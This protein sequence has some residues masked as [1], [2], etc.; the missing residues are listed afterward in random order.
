MANPSDQDKNGSQFFIVYK[1]TPESADQS[2]NPQSNLAPNYTVIGTVTGGMNIVDKVA[3]GGAKPADA[4]GNTAPKI[5]LDVKTMTVG[6]EK[7]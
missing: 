2:G 4:N 5:P 3:A 6:P 1:D 7:L